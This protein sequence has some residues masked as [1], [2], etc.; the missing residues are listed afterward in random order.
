MEIARRCCGVFGPIRVPDHVMERIAQ[1]FSDASDDALHSGMR[2]LV[3]L[4]RRSVLSE[5]LTP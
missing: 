5:A 4:P 2:C 3:H 1:L